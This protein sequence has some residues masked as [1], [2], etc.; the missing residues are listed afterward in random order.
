MKYRYGNW[1]YVQY[2]H[3]L[4]EV[5]IDIDVVFLEVTSDILNDYF[6]DE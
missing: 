3:K 5:K 2:W 1:I 4:C 6:L